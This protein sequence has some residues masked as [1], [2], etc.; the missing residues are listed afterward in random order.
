[1]S[2]YFITQEQGRRFAEQL[3]LEKI[4]EFAKGRISA[5]C[6]RHAFRKFRQHGENGDA[7]VNILEIQTLAALKAEIAL[8]NLEDVYNTSETGLFSNVLPDSAIA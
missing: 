8:Y 7:S 3:R 6:K 2:R 1:M 4:P 5:F